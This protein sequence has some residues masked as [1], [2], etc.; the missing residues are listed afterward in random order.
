MRLGGGRIRH[1]EDG[2]L[3]PS[4]CIMVLCVFSRGDG[5]GSL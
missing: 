5:V 3:G 1:N 4:G 2:G